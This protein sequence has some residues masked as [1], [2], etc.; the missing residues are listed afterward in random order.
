VTRRRAADGPVVILAL[1]AAA[2]LAAL[3][4]FVAHHTLPYG[5][6]AECE[7]PQ[8]T[9]LA[10]L[11]TIG[12]LIPAAL[13]AE[14]VLATLL[15]LAHQLWATRRTLSGVLAQ[16]VP[17]DARL[18]RLAA[19]A[20]LAPERLDLVADDDVYTFCHGLLRPRV[21][22]TTRL[23]AMLDDAELLAV[24]RHE[25]HHRRHR[26]PLKILLSRALSSGLFFLPLASALHDAY[27]AA[28][29]LCADADATA[30]G[31]ELPLARALVK[32]LGAA[33]PAW[34]AGVLAIG[35]FS[36]TEARLRRLVAPE[37]LRPLLPSPMDWILS[38]AIV[39][40][41]FG[42][43]H[44]AVTASA[45]QPLAAECA[46]PAHVVTAPASTFAARPALSH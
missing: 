43:S 6:F 38:L 33:R 14:V 37:D 18:A 32:L 9:F 22:L 45:A 36:P 17:L 2:L 46:A 13:T 24:L 28:K 29:E 25:A 35:S 16:R 12:V 31:D 26:D 41:I 11:G 3:V 34:P 30:G 39:A 27:L 4:A 23:A 42:F 40:G 7:T 1:V 10:R 5:L 44:G 21:C 15:A 19:A 8:A 20:A